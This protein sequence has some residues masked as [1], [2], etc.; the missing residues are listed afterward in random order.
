MSRLIRL[1]P[2]TGCDEANADGRAFHK[3][4]DGFFY[5]DEQYIGPLLHVGGFSLAPEAV[6]S[7]ALVADEPRPVTVADVEALARKLP[8]GDLK[9]QLLGVIAAVAKAA[10]RQMVK[11][12]PPVGTT[13]FSHNGEMFSEMNDDGTIDAPLESV[14]AL[15]DGPAGFAF[16]G[17]IESAPPIAAAVT[18]DDSE[19]ASAIDNQAAADAPEPEPPVAPLFPRLVIPNIPIPSHRL[20]GGG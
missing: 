17:H 20:A 15:C 4:D 11:V 7:A 16:V 2:P 12:R 13:W 19:S 5:V 10:P 3:H 6:A 14:D 1:I 9:A 18:V 8:K